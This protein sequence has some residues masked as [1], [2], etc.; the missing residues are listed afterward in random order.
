[1]QSINT[2]ISEGT[3]RIDSA[4]DYVT[5]RMRSILVS[6]GIPL[7]TALR[8]SAVYTHGGEW[9]LNDESGELASH[10][11]HLLDNDY[12]IETVRELENL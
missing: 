7:D 6:G 5:D 3:R 10:D 2:V 1:M 4:I 12:L 11:I 8:Y 9:I